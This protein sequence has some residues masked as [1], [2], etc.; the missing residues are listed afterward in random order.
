MWAFFAQRAERRR[1][2]NP[3]YE[4]LD[5]W[6]R[7]SFRPQNIAVWLRCYGRFTFAQ[8]QHDE[9]EQLLHF[10]ADQRKAVRAEFASLLK[11]LEGGDE[12]GLEDGPHPARSSVSAGN[13]DNDEA[14]EGDVPETMVGPG[15]QLV[16]ASA[17]GGASVSSTPRQSASQAPGP[18]SEILA[19]LAAESP[20]PTSEKKLV[21]L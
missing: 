6:I 3:L 9:A 4:P 21:D 14:N 5:D 18:S 7:P 15:E 13:D 16:A 19:A 8:A 1:I 17:N 20:G 2:E 10:L 12:P 11:E